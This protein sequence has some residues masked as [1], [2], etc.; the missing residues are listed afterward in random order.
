[1]LR[2]EKSRLR[3]AASEVVSRKLLGISDDD[4]E[5]LCMVLEIDDL[6]SLCDDMEKKDLQQQGHILKQVLG[7]QKGSS[8]AGPRSTTSEAANSCITE[9][10]KRKIGVYEEMKRAA[11]D[12]TVTLVGGRR[13][14]EEPEPDGQ[15][16][17]GLAD[18]ARRRDGIPG[19]TKN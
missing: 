17:R 7:R 18:Q 15:A 12:A 8:S 4:I 9:D 6:R 2:K 10:Q 19:P 5:N 13:A 14:S 11:L 3:A 16:S 1:M